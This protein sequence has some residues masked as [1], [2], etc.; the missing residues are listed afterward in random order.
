VLEDRAEQVASIL[1]IDPKI[2]AAAAA[3]G[4][5]VKD[6][7]ESQKPKQTT[8]DTTTEGET[9]TGVKPVAVDLSGGPD[10]VDTLTEAE[11]KEKN[12]AIAT[13]VFEDAGGGA[14]G[15]QAV[16]DTLKEND[17]TVADLADLT[18]LNETDINAFIDTTLGDGAAQ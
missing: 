12:L 10:I 8:L 7:L 1:G 16:L 5:S 14:E 18:G 13:Q 4:M 2:L 11:E 6:Y 3:A 17:L 15:V 9:E